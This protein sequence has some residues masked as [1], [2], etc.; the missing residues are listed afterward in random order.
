MNSNFRWH[1]VG[2]PDNE[3]PEPGNDL[4]VRCADGEFLKT[5]DEY[6]FRKKFTIA[7]Y[8]EDDNEFWITGAGAIAIYRNVAAWC[9]LKDVYE[10]LNNTGWGFDPDKEANN[11]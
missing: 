7:H 2:E 9:Y 1:H 8:D 4:I 10:Q 3:L 5:D 11:D 6:F